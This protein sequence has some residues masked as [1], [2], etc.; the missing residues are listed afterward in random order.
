MWCSTLGD[1]VAL[2]LSLLATS[3]TVAAQLARHVPRIGFL[4]GGTPAANAV[5]GAAFRQG[6]LEL[7][8]IERHN[9]VIEWH[10]AEGQ[11][12]RLP[13]LRARRL[14]HQ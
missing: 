7:G 9:L 5:R 1:I 13:A 11:L 6:L 3:G 8:Y 14:V 12:E 4:S 2:L 10:Y